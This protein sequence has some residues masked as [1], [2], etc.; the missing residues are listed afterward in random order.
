MVDEYRR[1]WNPWCSMSITSRPFLAGFAMCLALSWVALT[2]CNRVSPAGSTTVRGRVTF[3]GHPMAGGLVV[4]SP[5]PERGGSGK[6]IPG[7]IAQ[8]GHFQ[9]ILGSDPTIPPGWYRVAIAPD[10]Q[11]A[12]FPVDDRAA[13][14]PQLTRPDQSGLCREVKAGQENTF[15]FAIELP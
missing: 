4:F 13:F 8:D 14:P 5:D 12:T 15:D 2:G 10:P 1:T 3:Q 11:S 6:P 9:L 7:Q